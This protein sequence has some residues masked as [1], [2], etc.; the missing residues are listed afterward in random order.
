MENF[1]ILAIFVSIKMFVSHLSY[2]GSTENDCLIFQT[3]RPATATTKSVVPAA[4]PAITHSASKVESE[5]TTPTNRQDADIF[6]STTIV[7]SSIDTIATNATY[8]EKEDIEKTMATV[9]D[10]IVAAAEQAVVQ[11]HEID[12]WVASAA[13][14]VGAVVSDVENVYDEEIAPASLPYIPPTGEVLQETVLVKKPVEIPAID[15]SAQQ[16]Q[17][18][19]PKQV[20]E[21]HHLEVASDRP[22]NGDMMSGMWC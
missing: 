20:I 5:A 18:Q 3:P 21:S 17:P 14:S 12:S 15:V 9:V 11:K 8:T 10:E 19:Q 1:I 13:A 2:A 6:S 16:Q 4:P 22:D 7:D